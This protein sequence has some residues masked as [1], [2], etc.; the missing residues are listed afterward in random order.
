M[1]AMP[2]GYTICQAE[3]RHLP[4][5]NE[6]EMAASTIF[7][8]GFLPAHV[9]LDKMPLPILREAM[10]QSR[11]WVAL[12]ERENP[13]GYA[14]LQI[15]D[16]GAL[17]AQ[18]DVHPDHGRKGLGTALVKRVIE[19]SRAKGVLDLYLT[20]FANIRWNAPFYAKC[21]FV[22]LPASEQ[23]EFIKTILQEEQKHGLKDRIAMRY[24]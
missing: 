8:L 18:M 6:I 14:V 9:L 12:H 15:V 16:N 1:N 3:A 11:L 22:E 20:T 4:F 24:S 2:A 23:P 5:L 21:G 19:E 17:L 13:V 10:E 7:P